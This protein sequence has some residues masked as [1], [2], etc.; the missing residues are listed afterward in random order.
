MKDQ[1]FEIDEKYS[2]SIYHFNLQYV[3]GDVSTYHHLHKG[4]MK[5]FLR[6]FKENPQWCAS[7]EIQGHYLK[8]MEKFYPDDL[9]L[10]RKLNQR[11]QIEMVSVHYSDQIY[12]AYPER[13]IQ[14]SIDVNDG[15]FEELG[16][17]RSGVWFGQEN[18]FGQGIA[19]R[20]MERNNYH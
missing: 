6:F 11:D 8:F 4:S 16:L 2:L 18:F 17:K 1:K 15:I 14:Q 13:D 12:L 20:I 3:A 9:A 19:E 7:C 10:L 5:P